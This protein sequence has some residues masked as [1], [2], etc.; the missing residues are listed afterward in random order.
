L[1]L[2]MMSREDLMMADRDWEEDFCLV[3]ISEWNVF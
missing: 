3:G 1:S 2:R